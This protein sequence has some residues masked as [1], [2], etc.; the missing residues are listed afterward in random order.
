MAIASLDQLV[1]EFLQAGPAEKRMQER[2]LARLMMFVRKSN[3]PHGGLALA[4]YRRLEA[5]YR[6]CTP[7][8]KERIEQDIRDTIEE[9]EYEARVAEMLIE[10]PEQE[11]AELRVLHKRAW[12]GDRSATMRLRDKLKSL[13]GGE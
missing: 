13:S 2:E 8:Q 10:F 12:R 11:R 1:R 5:L 3:E 6:A 4:E 7:E 9:D